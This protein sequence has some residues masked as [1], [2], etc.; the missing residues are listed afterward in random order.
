MPAKMK[1]IEPRWER[2]FNKLKKKK[3]FKVLLLVSQRE[4]V[5]SKNAPL[6]PNRWGDRHLIYIVIMKRLYF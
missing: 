1:L 2:A 3:W 4:K 6:P 5:S